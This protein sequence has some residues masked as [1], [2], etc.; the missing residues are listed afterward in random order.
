MTDFRVC[1]LV[2]VYN[3]PGTISEV[4]HKLSDLGLPVLLIDD[5]SSAPNAEELDQLSS[6]PD[7]HLLRLAE[8]HGK[9]YAVRAGLIMAESLGFT[10]ALQVDA[11]AQHAHVSLPAFLQQGERHPQT[12]FAGYACYDDSVP[13]NRF[14]GRYLTHV[15]VW[16][17]TLSLSIR[18]SMCG[19]RL[20]P[21]TA[22]NSL[23][24][25]HDCTDRMAFDTEVLV[26]WYWSGRPISNLPVEVHYPVGGVSHFAMWRDN[27]DISW[28]HTRLFFGMLLRLP[29]LSWRKLR[30]RSNA[31][32]P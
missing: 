28:M 9:G 31:G 19:V 24:A 27:R 8:N 5:G 4:C 6:A 25:R 10:H 29:V 21:L 3:H 14:Y 15:W 18:D 2:P 11:D 30:T 23:L 22:I 12:L 17:N 20:Y 26:R 13:K 1:A 32:R 16:I 7:V